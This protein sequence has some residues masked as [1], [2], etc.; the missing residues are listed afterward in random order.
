MIFSMTLYAGW[1][2]DLSTLEEGEIEIE[3]TDI[4]GT[5]SF[6]FENFGNSLMVLIFQSTT[7]S[8]KLDSNRRYNKS[9]NFANW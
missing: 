8:T 6:N 4:D 3:I 5:S 7:Y 2:L 1:E 9:I